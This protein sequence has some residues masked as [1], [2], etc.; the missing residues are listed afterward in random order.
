VDT[1]RLEH[2]QDVAGTTKYSLPV[3]LSQWPTG[4]L[5]YFALTLLVGSSDV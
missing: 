5:Q 1:W 2:T 3:L 4:F